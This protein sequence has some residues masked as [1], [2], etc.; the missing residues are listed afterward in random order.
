MV[1]AA[2]GSVLMLSASLSEVRYIT[3][4][5]VAVEPGGNVIFV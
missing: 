4:I 2:V 3:Y 1:I 5:T